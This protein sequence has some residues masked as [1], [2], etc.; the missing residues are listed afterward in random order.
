MSCGNLPAL[1]SEALMDEIIS[2]QER[3]VA[4]EHKMDLL[5]AGMRLLLAEF[6]PD[7]EAKVALSD[8]LET[9]RSE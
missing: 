1:T 5:L 4:I 3:I 6:D 7:A 2:A 9:E 8:A